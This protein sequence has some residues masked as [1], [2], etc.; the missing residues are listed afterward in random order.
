MQ[1]VNPKPSYCAAMRRWHAATTWNNT[2]RR[3]LAG[4]VHRLRNRALG[5]AFNRWQEAVEDAKDLRERM[6]RAMA[7]WTNRQVMGC[8]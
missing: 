2:S 6:R 3:L 8:C 1:L 4:A 7:R 5:A